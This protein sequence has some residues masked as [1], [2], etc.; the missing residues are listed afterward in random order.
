V[1]AAAAADNYNNKRLCYYLISRVRAVS[2]VMEAI[3][4]P[5]SLA[6]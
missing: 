1:A 6:P 2:F 3:A 4:V 5:S